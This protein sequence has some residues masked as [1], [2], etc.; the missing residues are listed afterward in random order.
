MHDDPKYPNLMALL[1]SVK[2]VH[3]FECPPNH[4]SFFPPEQVEVGDFPELTDWEDPAPA[5]ESATT[6]PPPPAASSS[7]ALPAPEQPAPAP[8]PAPP[9]H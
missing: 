1:S 9:S 6:T 3:Y 2:G 5:D 4:G 8:A 7:T